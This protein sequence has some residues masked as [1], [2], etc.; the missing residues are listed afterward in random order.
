MET[1]LSGV[2]VNT[3]WRQFDLRCLAFEGLQFLQ[4]PSDV[5]APAAFK[6]AAVLASSSMQLHQRQGCAEPT[7]QL[8]GITGWSSGPEAA[9]SLPMPPWLCPVRAGAAMNRITVGCDVDFGRR[10][11]DRLSEKIDLSIRNDSLFRQTFTI[12]SLLIEN[13]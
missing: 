12:S 13:K 5:V 10:K 4:A 9:A 2:V 6:L 8:H 1:T 7:S 11:R 3:F